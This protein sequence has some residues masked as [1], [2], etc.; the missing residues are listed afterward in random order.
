MAMQ[1]PS[2]FIG[3][4]RVRCAS[5]GTLAATDGQIAATTGV[6]LFNPWTG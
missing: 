1:E 4:K 5:G 2:H 6:R 3:G